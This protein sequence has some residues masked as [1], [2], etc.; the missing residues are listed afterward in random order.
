MC[1]LS[2][3]LDTLYCLNSS[4]MINTLYVSNLLSIGRSFWY[5]LNLNIIL[6]TLNVLSEF[7]T[8]TSCLGETR[9]L[10]FER[11]SFSPHFVQPQQRVR[12]PA[13]TT[14]YCCLYNLSSPVLPMAQWQKV[15]GSNWVGIGVRLK[16][17]LNQSW[18][19]NCFKVQL[20]S[21]LIYSYLVIHECLL[22]PRVTNQ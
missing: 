21:P 19:Q 3:I 15:L 13:E 6:D 17:P 8:V 7:I 1:Y 18:V 12:N 16:F 2:V 11:F 14:T 22:L 20:V 5:V 10:Y 9:D 4:A